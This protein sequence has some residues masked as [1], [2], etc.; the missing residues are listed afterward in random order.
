MPSEP[1]RWEIYMI[2]RRNQHAKFHVLVYFFL[3]WHYD[4]NILYFAKI[5]ALK[6]LIEPTPA[7]EISP[8]KNDIS[9]TE[10]GGSNINSAYI[11][12]PVIWWFS[13]SSFLP[14]LLPSFLLYSKH[15][16]SS[17]NY[18]IT[19]NAFSS[20]INSFLLPFSSPS[21]TFS[22]TTQ[23]HIQLGR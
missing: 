19:W 14:P 4:E 10:P 12:V 2:T 18:T 23:Q 20:G 7:V 8:R 17:K 9:F 22:R 16:E 5:R 15:E 13:V 6:Y 11:W 1:L 3:R 21:F